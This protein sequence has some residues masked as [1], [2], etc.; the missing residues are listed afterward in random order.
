[1]RPRVSLLLRNWLPHLP[2]SPP[3]SLELQRPSPTSSS[4]LSSCQ[5]GG[6]GKGLWAKN[7][8]LWVLCSSWDGISCSLC[9]C[10]FHSPC[11]APAGTQRQPGV[12]SGAPG[13]AQPWLGA[14]GS[15]L[16]CWVPQ[17]KGWISAA[18][19]STQSLEDRDT[20]ASHD[21]RRGKGKGS[22]TPQWLRWP[23]GPVLMTTGRNRWDKRPLE[24]T[25]QGGRGWIT[26]A[27]QV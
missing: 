10:S 1:V 15:E 14:M 4:A 2:H 9:Q 12:H 19:Q 27:G 8:G 22:E 24:T 13:S 26:G 18:M 21:V 6:A 3:C 20:P 11:V 16:S 7:H 17:I 5:G 25:P 23:A